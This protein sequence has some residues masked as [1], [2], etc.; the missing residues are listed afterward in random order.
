MKD[1]GKAAGS[2][3][4][5]NALTVHYN[6]TQMRSDTWSTLAESVRALDEGGLDRKHGAALRSRIHDCFVTLEPLEKYFAFPGKAVFRELRRQFERGALENVASVVAGVGRLIASDSYRTRDLSALQ[7]FGSTHSALSENLVGNLRPEK[8]PYFE[9]LL[10]E[11]MGADEEMQLRHRLLDMRRESD[12]FVY[13]VVVVPSVEDALIAA[14]LNYNFQAVVIR[15]DFPFRATNPPEV[16]RAMLPSMPDENGPNALWLGNAIR[17]LRPELDQFLVTD[18]P[19]ETVAGVVDSCFRRIFYRQEDYM[20]L[21]LSI[22]K[23]IMERFSTP[24]FA[25]LREYSHKP[26]GVFHAMPISRGKSIAKSHWIGDMGKF[27]GTNIFLA[28]TSATTGGLDSLLQPQGPLKKAQ[29]QAARAFGSR[30]TFFVTNGTSTANKIVVQALVRPGDIVLIDRDCHKSHHYGLVLSGAQP[31]YLDSYPLSEYS[32]Y[33]AVPLAEIKRQL[34]ALDKA[35]KLDQ[36]K[37]LLLTN[38]TFDGVAYNPERVMHEVLAIKP[39]M[40]FLWDE[41]WFAYGHFTPLTRRRTAM[42]AARRL[43]KRYRSAAYRQEYE[44]YKKARK[45]NGSSAPLMPDPDRVA[46]RVYATQSTHKTL[47]ALRQGSMIHT[48]DQYFEQR[49]SEAFH[50]A[51]MT[52]TCTSPN[53]QILAS[54]DVGRR[55]VELE[56]YELVQKSIELALMLR[57]AV[58]RHPLLSRYFS[59]LDPQDMIPTQYRP[60][61]IEVYHDPEVEWQH[62]E[63]AWEGDEFVLDP[64]RL[65]LDVGRTGMDG[66]TFKNYLMDRY[67]IQINKTSRNTVLFMIHIG[68]TRGTVAYL[69]DVLT[70]IAMELDDTLEHSDETD[71]AIFAARVRSLTKELPPLP[72]FSHFHAAFRPLRPQGT[73]EADLRAAF[74]MAYD[75]SLLECVK[76]DEA[77]RAVASGRELVSATF[78][79]PYPPGFP[80]LVPGQVVSAEILG[81]L[82]ALDVKEI[83]GYR[84]DHGLLVFKESALA[85]RMA[86]RGLAATV[87]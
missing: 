75:E 82:K 58:Q 23:G 87:K 44:A 49:V 4:A 2:V 52:H 35:G 81:F 47:T 66:D 12:E 43:Y 50:E 24:F 63:R 45:G 37:M 48:H 78:V 68:T 20:E 31:I 34:L 85:A 10:V 1:N 73:A 33:G 57:N 9:V 22:L 60:S 86:E 76:L 72:N 55:Q 5:P 15:Y 11:N 25:A 71:R 84:A 69:I 51:Y 80:V 42:E 40:V 41:A 29:E 26:T 3:A 18:E 54:L 27:Y 46:V 74:F 79:I 39:D 38:I 32:M 64:T 61:G 59:F 13:D 56:G 77:V 8:R 30:R 62:M 17:S 28:E 83:H 70:K 6:A 67:D 19:L 14:L 7:W 65:T 53:Y 21:H 36:V 16:L